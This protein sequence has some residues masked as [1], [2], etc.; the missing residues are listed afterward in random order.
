MSLKRLAVVIVNYRKPGIVIDCLKS[1]EAQLEPG[2]DVAIVVDYGSGGG[3]SAMRIEQAIDRNRWGSWVMLTLS[4]GSGGRS[5]GMN[6][7]IQ[8]VDAEAYF[9]LDSDTVVRDDTIASLLE[10]M[11]VHP[12]AGVVAPRVEWP[13]ASAQIS[14]FRFPT[15]QTEFRRS[16][17]PRAMASLLKAVEAPRASKEDR[18]DFEWT[19]L[20]STLIRRSVFYDIGFLDQNYFMYFEDVDF[21]RRAHDAGWKMVHWPGARVVHLGG[22][23]SPIVARTAAR[24]RR[25]SH[26][27]EA[28]AR[29]F[30]VSYGKRGL[31]LA[32]CL[33]TIGRLVSLFSE[34]V[35]RREPHSSER[36]WRDIWTNYSDPG[37]SLSAETASPDSISAA[38][39][40]EPETY[41]ESLE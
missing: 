24:K 13:D 9:L 41:A 1:L 19:S 21:C 39:V 27:Y 23:T 32:N 11:D 16:A 10:A 15:P 12:E 34:V 25:P 38:Q 30:D 8:T 20:G 6:A 26:Y 18:P 35:F 31:F 33:W 40:A 37:R 28:R 22:G 2:L 4:D 17:A 5:A 14:M 29:Y 7:G 3:D 36:E